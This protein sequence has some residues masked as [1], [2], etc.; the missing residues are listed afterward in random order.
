VYAQE[1]ELEIPKDAIA[2]TDIPRSEVEIVFSDKDSQSQTKS[3]FVGEQKTGEATQY[4]ILLTNNTSKPMRITGVKPQCGCTKLLSVPPPIA[5]GA[6]AP[7]LIS[8][9]PTKPYFPSPQ[10]R[11]DLTLENTLTPLVLLVIANISHAVSISGGSEAIFRVP[12]TLE[13]GAKD[14]QV[15]FDIELAVGKKVDVST[16]GVEAAGDVQFIN[17][18]IVRSDNKTFVKGLCS[19]ADVPPTT[20]RGVIRIV[21]KSA[22]KGDESDSLLVEIPVTITNPPPIL[23]LPNAMDFAKDPKSGRWI[24]KGLVRLDPVM[25]KP[26]DDSVSFFLAS[27]DRGTLRSKKLGKLLYN[28]EIDL[29]EDEKNQKIPKEFEVGVV[30]S[31]QEFKLEG[32]VK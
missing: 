2:V 29:I 4:K 6:T 17:W 9:E 31:G 11:I 20:T 5:V 10:Y 26:D 3:I 14:E 23:L 24:G 1:G 21:N 27:P 7:L 16:L 32:K 12:P 13:A 15:N 8:V 28:V 30:I 25:I 19:S 22:K 18:K